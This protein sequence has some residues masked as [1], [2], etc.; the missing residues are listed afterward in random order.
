MAGYRE[1]T[2]AQLE[3]LEEALDGVLLARTMLRNAIGSY[4]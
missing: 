4:F 3:M 1:L 2:E